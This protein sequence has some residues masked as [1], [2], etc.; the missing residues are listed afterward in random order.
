[1]PKYTACY[2]CLACGQALKQP[3]NRLVELTEDNIV[4][5]VG[6]LADS[7]LKYPSAR[8]TWPYSYVHDC[9]GK[10]RQF[11]TA[12]FAGIVLADDD[13]KTNGGNN[14]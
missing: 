3:E 6:M 4:P 2:R 14:G 10:G 5:I 1:M 13:A 11:G 12:I 9:W 8:Y 7:S